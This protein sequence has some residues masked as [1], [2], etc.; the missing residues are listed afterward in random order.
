MPPGHGRGGQLRAQNNLYHL[1]SFF[2]GI[3]PGLR[4]GPPAGQVQAWDGR[5][6]APVA[7]PSCASLS[8]KIASSHRPQQLISRTVALSGMTFCGRHTTALCH[9]QPFHPPTK[10]RSLRQEL[11][12]RLCLPPGPGRSPLRSP[13]AQWSLGWPALRLAC[14]PS[15]RV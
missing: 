1:L 12:P 14:Y 5:R 13:A 11:R 8:L 15:Y 4:T 7:T 6:S 9:Q 3:F 2:L 10:I